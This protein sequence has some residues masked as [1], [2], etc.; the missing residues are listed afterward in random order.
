MRKNLIVFL[1]VILVL[2]TACTAGVGNLQTYVSANQGYEFKYPNGWVQVMVEDA[3][4]G[5]DVVF[6][7]I[8]EQSE[9]LSLIISDV[10]PDKTLS[11]LGTP[12]EVGYRF[13]K[14]TNQKNLEREVELISAELEKNEGNVYYILEYAVTFANQQKRHNIAS[15]A[16]SQGQLF[17]FNLSTV[18]RRWPQVKGV[19]N[20]VVRSFMVY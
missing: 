1:S 5:V 3:S 16:V 13:L 14:V 7:D 11:E 10:P 12:S 8:V 9:N 4:E 20:A 17:T 6:R 18:E 15:V 19:F 2:L